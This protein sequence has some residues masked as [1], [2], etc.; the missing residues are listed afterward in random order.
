[1]KR[2][3]IQNFY[4]LNT[5]KDAKI[6][7]FQRNGNEPWVPK[8][9]SIAEW[10][11]MT[12]MRKKQSVKSVLSVVKKQLFF[13]YLAGNKILRCFGMVALVFG[14]CALPVQAEDF[15]SINSVKYL[16]RP[17]K[18]G[19]GVWMFVVK[20]PDKTAIKEF[21]QCLEVNVSVRENTRSDELTAKA[22]FFDEGNHLI[23][24]QPAPS[25]SGTNFMP[26][27]F[28]MPVLFYKNK[29]DRFFF[30][31]PEAVRNRQWKAVVVFGDKDEAKSAC[32]PASET[33]FLLDYPEKTLVKDNPAKKTDRKPAMDPLIEEVVKTKNRNMP[34]ITLFLRPPKGVSDP[35]EVKGVL[36]ICV[37][38]GGIDDIKRELQK[39]E[40]PGDYE[41]LFDFANK[42]KLA[43]LAWG[44]HSMWDPNMNHDELARA[45]AKAM[46]E[47]FDTVAEAWER[48]V[49]ELCEKYGLPNHDFLLW[50]S[51][52]SAQWAHRLCLRK[53][54]YFLAIDIHIPGSFDKPTPQ[55]SK[56]LWCLTTGELYG[57]YQRSLRFEKECRKLGYP[58]VYK[59]VEGLGHSGSEISTALGFKFFEFALTLKESRDAYDKKMAEVFNKPSAVISTPGQPTTPA[60]P[61]PEI[62]QHPPYYGDI[63]NQEMYPADQM[64][65]IPQ[66]F[67]VPLPTKE[68]A[69]AWNH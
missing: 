27:N 18:D 52:G 24:A 35:A 46:D 22:Y 63:V 14:L 34:Q 6:K 62:F 38:A 10:T 4:P 3:K 5:R 20:E 42:H 11:R 47:S 66:G 69:D 23:I 55:A 43:I 7:D 48:G 37:L 64:D 60:Q 2:Q 16:D 31:V 29:P 9:L 53:P 50:G 39:E 51:C 8:V 19:C 68:L 67:R 65:M 61:W 33:D 1:M 32:Y 54:D 59:A 25:K 49:K 12:R 26:G 44:S 36:A 13:A 41:G 28:E 30:E 21:H 58:M 15:F 40:M 56:V 45:Q 57:G 17:P